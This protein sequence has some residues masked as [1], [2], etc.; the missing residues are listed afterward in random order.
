MAQ[1]CG[2]FI[3]IYT[4]GILA[5]CSL[6]LALLIKTGTRPP[7]IEERLLKHPLEFKESINI[8]DY[9]LENSFTQTRL[10]DPRFVEYQQEL[11]SQ[12]VQANR[13]A[14]QELKDILAQLG[15]ELDIESDDSKGVIEATT[16]QDSERS[17]DDKPVSVRQ[18]KQFSISNEPYRIKPGATEYQVSIRP[19]NALPNL[20]RMP[21]RTLIRYLIHLGMEKD[22]AQ[23][24]GGVIHD[25]IDLDDF[26]SEA[27]AESAQYPFGRAPRNGP[28]K[29]WS[30]VFYLKGANA[31][32][33]E[34]L[35]NHFVLH[36]SVQKIDAD[37][38]KAEALAVLTDIPVSEVIIALE[39]ESFTEEEKLPLSE[40][41]S[42]ENAANFLDQ[43]GW[44]SDQQILLVDV[45]GPSVRLSALFDVR[46]KQILDWYLNR[47]QPIEQMPS[48]APRTSP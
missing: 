11:V 46:E 19:A 10:M 33:V 17:R 8:L 47:G 13:G 40:L 6:V 44:D 1:G 25:W 15:M 7:S 27:G 42:E 20:N 36:S 38:F 34:F 12:S 18:A 32:L 24:L 43:V 16:T 9:V 2:G 29:T 39:N 23:R 4:L 41:I 14:L 3:L 21:R 31:R 37:Y 30:E 26:L 48:A 45:Q 22:Q 28:L 35:R 5:A